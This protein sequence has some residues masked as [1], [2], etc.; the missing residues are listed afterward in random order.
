MKKLLATTLLVPVLAAAQ[1]PLRPTD[2]PESPA[3]PRPPTTRPTSPPTGI[4][5]TP[6]PPGTSIGPGGVAPISPNGARPPPGRPTSPAPRPGGAATPTPAPARG[7]GGEAET[8][9]PAANGKCVPMQGRFMLT[10]NRAEVVDVLEQ[11]SRWTCRNFI[12]TE[13]VARGKITLLSKTPVTAEEAYA[14]FLAALNANNITVYPTGRY[15]RLGR[16][17]DS[18]K[19]P[20]PTYTDPES[21]TP[22]SEQV[23]TKVI[24]LQY[25]DADQLRGVMG[26]FI[27]P[28]GADI[29]SIPPSTLVITDTGLNIRR[30]EKMIEAIDKVGGGDLVRIVQVRYASAKDLADKV[31]QIFQAQGGRSPRPARISSAGPGRPGVPTT[32]PAGG[33]VEVSVYKVLPDDRTNKLIVIADEKSFQQIMELVQQLDVPTSA[34]GGVHV[35]FLKNANAEELA[36]TLSNLAQGQAKRTTTPGAPTQPAARPAGMP[37]APPA[38][39]TPA[40]AGEVTAE[41]FSGEVKITADKTQNAL[42][43]QASGADFAA[44]Q[45]LVEKLDRPRRQVFVEAVIM[46]VNLKNSMELGVSAHGAIPYKYKGD[47]GVIPLSSQTGRVNSLDMSSAIALGGFLTGYTGPI[48][49]ELKDLGF[50]NIPSLG[51]LIQALQSNSDV[52]VLS[53]PHLLATDNEESEITVG[54][55]VPFQS[56]YA[57]S[58]LSNLLSGS[59]TGA[60]STVGSALGTQGLSSLYAPIQ[61]QNVEL[62]L[63]IKPQIN[64]GGNIRL[65]IEEQTEEIAEKDPQLGPTTAKRSVKTQIVARDQ[66]TIVI[67]GLIQDRAIRSVSK[68]PFL[69]SL[70]ILGWL[71]RD[72]TTTKQK[73]NLLLF[74]TPYIIRDEADYRRIYEKKREEQQQFIEQFYGRQPRYDVDVD[75]SRK[76]GPYS[77]LRQGVS[78][79]TSRIENGGGGAPGEYLSAPPAGGPPST[80]VVPVPRP[81]SPAPPPE[82]EAAPEA[83]PPPEGTPEPIERLSPQQAPPAGEPAAPGGT[84]PQE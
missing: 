56:G 55:N 29:Q 43:V 35:L 2:D 65:S 34:D 5:T 23:I 24:R 53:T 27:S 28:Q 61:R 1:V 80:T 16:A 14:A 6:P 50:G 57:P 3:R 59:G 25:A 46:E 30:I 15:W 66:S 44:V 64:E 72:T 45:R 9:L 69:G 39:A 49:A 21:G 73:V 81:T 77:R 10:F 52:N 68:I 54:Q 48:S 38:A 17:A 78:Q 79:E 47:T 37:G 40:P 74:L 60:S 13:D 4:P 12:Y 26:N 67:G 84:P 58:G 11:A 8:T 20:I 76:T 41:L 33:A 83:A 42:L 62:K 82:P 19:M 7:G 70:P 22:A 31:N 51:L 36:T 75:F 32:Q 71:F 18:K 63:K